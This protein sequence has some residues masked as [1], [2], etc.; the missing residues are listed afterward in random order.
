VIS[1]TQE[2]W[3]VAP[4]QYWYNDAWY[5]LIGTDGFATTATY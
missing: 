5:N 1:Q 4:C 2:L 3:D